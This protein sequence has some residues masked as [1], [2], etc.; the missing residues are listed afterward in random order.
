M[1]FTGIKLCGARAGR[2]DW[3]LATGI[4]VSGPLLWVVIR[5]MTVEVQQPSVSASL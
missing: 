1:S 4:I 5:V 3:Q 2:D